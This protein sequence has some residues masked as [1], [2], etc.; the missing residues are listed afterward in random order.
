M[1]TIAD[2][3][4]SQRFT[5][6]TTQFY[7]PVTPEIL[8]QPRLLHFNACAGELIGLSTSAGQSTHAA[9]YLCGNRLFNGSQPVA[10]LYAGHQF[11][12]YVP[13][14]GDGRAMLLGEASTDNDR[15][16]LQLKGSGRT[17]YSRSGDG[18]AVL[19][20]SLREYL[21]SEAMFGLGVPTTRA[22]SLVDSPLPIWRETEETAAVVL[23]LSPS[24]VR[25]GS[26]E[27]FYYRKEHEHIRTLA[28]FVIQH[29]F[30]HL[31]GLPDRHL[32]LLSEVTQLTARLMAHWQTVGFTHG[33]MNTDNMSI[34]GL[35]LDYG[36]FG[37]MD[38]Y[39]PNFV[40]NHT[41][42]TGR[43]AFDQQ[44]DIAG[45]N[46]TRLAQAL[47]PLIP[48][49]TAHEALQDYPSLFA[50]AYI[51][52]MSAKLGLQPQRQ[53]A[54]LILPM[55][56]ILRDNRVDY[57]QFMRRLCDFNSSPTALNAPL[58][59]LF[60]QRQ[61]FDDWAASYRAAVNE[62]PYDDAQRRL[63]MLRANP[64]YI[65]RN[66][67]AEHIIQAVRD[68]GD[69]TIIEHIIQV[70]HAPYDEHPQHETWAH[71]PADGQTVMLSCSS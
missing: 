4:L 59:D 60:V 55:L 3:T 66:H 44:P 15:W 18:R 19:R 35:T 36:P 45:W 67:L 48:A 27:V 54:R 37:F 6:L 69:T 47:S 12:Y 1:D 38:Q 10:A 30:P 63:N 62:Q 33:V 8:P 23:R 16:E 20:S 32:R 29:H 70:L 7:T 34:L 64:K 43:Y 42:E 28:E 25:F 50:T 68:Q 9:D 24:F 49:D 39:N 52:L 51:D 11:G 58:R 17:P 31:Q 71:P 22:L 14:L 40:C 46:L 57:T 41:D 2:L 26:F 5:S 13:Q 56:D 61:T 53:N 21:C 65:L